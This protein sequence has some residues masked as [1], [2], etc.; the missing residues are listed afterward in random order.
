M[1][2][3]FTDVT[4]TGRVVRLEPIGLHHVDPLVAAADEDRSTYGLTLVPADHEAMTAYVENLVAL[5]D[6]G[7][8]V[9][10]ATCDA[11][12]GR[13]VGSTSFLT[14]RWYFGREVPDAVEIGRT[15]LA[16][17]AQRTAVN[18]E[19]KLLM[20]THAFETWEVVRVDLKTDERNARSRAAIERIGGRLDGIVRNWQPSFVPGEE[21][22]PRNS[23]MYSII[24]EE[25]PDV[26]QGLEARLG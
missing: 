2:P 22:R 13:V 1:A 9:P 14:L 10:F 16:A 17:S 11:T 6:R 12:T 25:W 19:A 23:A 26:R 4:L 5:R 7:E 3:A 8:D 24:P 20:L 21:G 18:T 15:W